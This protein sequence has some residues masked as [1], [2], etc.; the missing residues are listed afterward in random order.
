MKRLALPESI[1]RINKWAMSR[2]TSLR[3]VVL[4]LATQSAH[5][6]VVSNGVKSLR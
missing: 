5:G 6:I 3:E 4:P 1:T 2:C